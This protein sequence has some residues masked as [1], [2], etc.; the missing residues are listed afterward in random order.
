VRNRALLIGEGRRTESCVDDFPVDD[1]RLQIRMRDGCI[2]VG[3]VGNHSKGVLLSGAAGNWT[4][5]L[6]PDIPGAPAVDKLKSEML[7]V[8]SE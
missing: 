1:K 5:M 8:F 3:T 2:Y 6:G 7:Q 4:G